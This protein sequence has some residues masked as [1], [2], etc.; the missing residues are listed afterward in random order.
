MSIV[1]YHRVTRAPICTHSVSH[2]TPFTVRFL[3]VVHS[4]LHDP[5]LAVWEVAGHTDNFVDPLVECLKCHTRLRADKLVE[6]KGMTLSTNPTEVDKYITEL[7]EKLQGIKLVC[8][9]C[10]STEFTPPRMFNLLMQTNCGAVPTYLRPETAQ[11]I[12]LN[13]DRV[14]QSMNASRLPLGIG[15]V[16]KAFRNE[17]SPRDFVFRMREFEQMELE[18]FCLPEESKMKHEEWVNVCV[19]F[20]KEIGIHSD[21]IRLKSY[22]KHE[23]AHYALAT[24]DIEYRFPFG[25]SELWGI[26]NRGDFDMKRHNVGARAVYEHQL[27]AHV[28]GTGTPAPVKPKSEKDAVFPHVVEPSVGVDRLILALL[29][30]AWHVKDVVPLP[31]SASTMTSTSTSTTSTEGG[32]SES[33]AAAAAAGADRRTVLSI[34]ED[35]APIKFAVLPV[36]SK[37]VRTRR[38]RLIY[39][40]H[41]LANAVLLLSSHASSYFTVTSSPPFYLLPSPF[42]SFRTSLRQR[43]RSRQS[44]GGSRTRPWI[45]LGPSASVT[46]ASTRSVLRTVSP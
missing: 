29:S 45:V 23:L 10:K 20:L 46:D 37:P 43:T 36:T 34:H 41:P 9:G 30:D 42:P 18:Y 5:F 8:P 6:D 25:W 7:Q 22:E 40:D 4:T 26:A 12:F 11:G 32:K 2:V 39:L 1:R 15:Q 16:G 33:T 27:L 14:R 17:I 3:A 24:T 38:G 19:D 21:N 44:C 13:F 35:L 28:P 31:L